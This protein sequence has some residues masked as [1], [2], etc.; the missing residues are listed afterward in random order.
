MVEIKAVSY[1]QA[2]A[3][4]F[5]TLRDEAK[6][7]MNHWAVRVRHSRPNDLNDP[8]HIKASEYGMQYSFYNDALEALEDNKFK[9][10]AGF[11][12]GFEASQPKWIS[13]EERLPGDPEDVIGE[14]V[15]ILIEKGGNVL[16]VVAGF[17]D[18]QEKHWVVYDGLYTPDVCDGCYATVRK[19]R[20]LPEPPKGD[21]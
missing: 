6:R 12:R 1:E 3:E 15:E 8:A 17:Y 7:K 9:Y 13:V 19:W 14:V 20:P 21:V 5:E 16:C 11:V 10:E 18:H 2:R 4:H